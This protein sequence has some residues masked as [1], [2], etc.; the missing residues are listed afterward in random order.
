METV[1]F[2][3]HSTYSDGALT[4]LELRALMKDRGVTHFSVTDHDAIGANRELLVADPDGMRFVTGIE[5]TTHY[6]EKTLHLLA[7][8]F[9]PDNP[10]LSEFL[11][12]QRLARR[13]RAEAIV[14]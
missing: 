12:R 1:D 4:P 3:A 10:E 13:K 11:M 7:Y 14:E 5:L 9:H 6:R 2:H 8:G